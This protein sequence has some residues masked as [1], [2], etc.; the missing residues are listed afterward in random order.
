MAMTATPARPPATE[1]DLDALPDHLAGHIVDGELVTLPRPDP[2]H[3]GT[4]SDLAI[5]LGPPFRFGR[6]GPG[7]WVLLIE[8]KVWIGDDL[9]VPDLAAWRRE[10]FVAP[11]KGAYRVVP[12]WACELL[13]PSTAAFDRGRKLP[14]YARAGVGHCWVI[15]PIARTL[16][17]M[18]RQDDVWLL[19]ATHT[20]SEVVRAEP[21]E[22]VELD[23][24]LI[25]VD[26]PP[27]D[28]GPAPVT[29]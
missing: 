26:L 11:R 20:G 22:A 17:V 1:R 29:P 15:D 23:L 18:R 24:S 13:S 9:L 6:G 5:L 4:A 8:P 28:D 27:D 10:R 2:P 12:D 7:G 21:F 14:R 16:D 3:T 19:V 25:W